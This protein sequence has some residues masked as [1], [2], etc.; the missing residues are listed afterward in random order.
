SDGQ[1]ALQN[2][3]VGMNRTQLDRRELQEKHVTV[4][5]RWRR[6]RDLADLVSEDF[7]T[8]DFRH[9]TQGLAPRLDLGIAGGESAQA[10][11]DAD[12]AGG[13]RGDAAIEVRDQRTQALRRRRWKIDVDTN[14][15]RRQI[16][17]RSWKRRQEHGLSIEALVEGH[18]AERRARRRRTLT[19]S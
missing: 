13:V 12:A 7:S 1:K 15:E 14:D 9:G 18:S 5:G 10:D 19:A 16:S 3:R 4:G 8:A 17:D 11:D 2:E 6:T